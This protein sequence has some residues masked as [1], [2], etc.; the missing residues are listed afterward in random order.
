MYNNF[1][2][3]TILLYYSRLKCV[4]EI[5][6]GENLRRHRPDIYSYSPL[7]ISAEFIKTPAHVPHVQ[8]LIEKLNEKTKKKCKI[9]VLDKTFNANSKKNK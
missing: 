6:R 2:I 4:C 9:Y 1:E 8:F 3:H 7:I 5:T